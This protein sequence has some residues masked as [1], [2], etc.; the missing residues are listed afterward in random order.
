MLPGRISIIVTAP[1][2][3]IYER[4]PHTVVVA[5]ALA[6]RL[7]Q[8]HLGRARV[9]RRQHLAGFDVLVLTIPPT[10]PGVTRVESVDVDYSMGAGRLWQ[11]GSETMGPETSLKVG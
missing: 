4:S 1:I 10:R 11:H 3:P 5:L 8:R 2:S 7:Q 9:D 6:G